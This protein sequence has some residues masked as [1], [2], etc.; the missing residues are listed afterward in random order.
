M[1]LCQNFTDIDAIVPELLQPNARVLIHGDPGISTD[2]V[3]A[4]VVLHPIDSEP[5]GTE[6]ASMAAREH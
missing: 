2:I 5:P 1:R 4:E 6:D 3:A